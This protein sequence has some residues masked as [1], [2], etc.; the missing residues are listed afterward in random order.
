MLD[1]IAVLTLA[2]A[3]APGVAPETMAA[4]AFVESR[5]DPLAIGVNRGAGLNRQ[6][7]DRAEAVR[8]ARA[9]LA[10]GGNLDLGLAQINSRNLGWLGLTVED[11]FE[12]CRNLAAAAVVL[13]AGYRPAGETP[14]ERQA[15]LR[16]AL[17]RYN[18]GDA[19][20]G[21]RNGYVARVEAAAVGLS[22]T[23]AGSPPRTPT[24]SRPFVTG[25]VPGAQDVF[26]R[27]R[28]GPLLAFSSHPAGASCHVSSCV[29]P[30]PSRGGGHPRLRRQP[31]GGRPRLRRRQC[32]GTAAECGG[33][34]D[35]QHRPA[36]GGPGRG[37]CRRAV[38]VRPVRPAPGG[39]CG[40]GHSGGLRRR[41]DRQPDH[42][43]RLMAA[44][45]FG[46]TGLLAAALLLMAGIR[47]LSP[48]RLARA[49]GGLALGALAGASLLA[50]GGHG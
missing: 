49:T 23:A 11:A 18:T 37:H 48:G 24:P 42:R 22:L 43:R 36:A 1:L 17:S 25:A 19:R 27:A 6:P 10:R 5:F 34:S 7:R 32:G 15:A 50:G 46:A 21:L 30:P 4:V 12:P 29:L 38:D 33:P 40:S 41:G 31:G 13:K 35:R 14:A 47:L 16:T 28:T 45:P 9:L 2:Q 3:C 44:V 8:T 26:D 20:R 39:H